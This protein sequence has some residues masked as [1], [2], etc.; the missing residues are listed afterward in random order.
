MTPA[1]HMQAISADPAF[2]R[3]EK[4]VYALACLAPDA[5]A[6]STR[7]ASGQGALLP[8]SAE[9]GSCRRCHAP[10]LRAVRQCS[11]SL[12]ILPARRSARAARQTT[13]CSR[14]VTTEG[15]TM[16]PDRGQELAAFQ[17]RASEA[18]QLHRARLEQ[19]Q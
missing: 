7:A 18:V 2:V 3:L 11:I 4:G 19:V 16:M 8:Q 15:N 13:T 1:Y 12:Y 5:E 6:H 10:P 9:D 17:Q 14:M